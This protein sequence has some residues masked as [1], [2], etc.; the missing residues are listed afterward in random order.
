MKK[1]SV[2]IICYNEER[3]I[4]ECLS[5]VVAQDYKPI[6][7][8][9]ADDGSTDNTVEI[10]KKYKVSLL[11]LEHKGTA[12]TRNFAAK[13]A[14]GDI[15]VFLDA[16]MEFEEDFITHLV[17]PI[18][19]EKVK[20]TFSKLEYV[21]NWDNPLARCWNKLNPELPDKLRVS[22][23]KEEGDDFRAILKSEFE[24][25]EGFDD[26]GYTDTWSLYKKLGYK[27]VNAPHA[28][29][30]HNNPDS[31]K[32]LYSSARWIGKRAYK[33]G[34]VGSLIAL[35][36]ATPPVSLMK[37]VYMAVKTGESY[38]VPFYFVYD[39]GITLGIVSSILFKDVKK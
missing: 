20:G 22:Q 12:Y 5:S 21:R 14:T 30:Y 10:I 33:W 24:L 18:N 32:E 16:D 4:A 38:F 25:V 6:E 3:Y 28:K 1:V 36:R 17:M 29:Y 23:T 2:I 26:T 19:E 8:I 7:I 31:F 15:L 13:K 35:L 39:F 27:P 9:V 34:I 11:Q 37:G